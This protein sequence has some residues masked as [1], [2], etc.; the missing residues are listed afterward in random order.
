MLEVLPFRLK[1]TQSG[2]LQAIEAK[3]F[4]VQTSTATAIIQVSK[5]HWVSIYFILVTVAL[6][7]QRKF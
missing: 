1:Q 6:R 3:M 7:Q 5:K 4:N 2:K